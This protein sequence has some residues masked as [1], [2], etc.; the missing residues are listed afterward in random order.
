MTILI[1][2]L[3]KNYREFGFDYSK[4]SQLFEV[5]LWYFNVIVMWGNE[6]ELNAKYR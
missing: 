5:S 1:Y 6:K 2:K 4:I 3:R